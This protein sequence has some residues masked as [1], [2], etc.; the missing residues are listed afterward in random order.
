MK[1]RKFIKTTGAAVTL[2]ILLNGFGI[3]AYGQDSLLGS[4]A[5]DRVM[6]LIQLNGGNDGLNTVIPTDQYTNL[7]KALFSGRSNKNKNG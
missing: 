6:V 1:R 4:L 3:K 7:Q 2:P 5:E